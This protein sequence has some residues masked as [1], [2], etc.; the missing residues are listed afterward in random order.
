PSNR[1]PTIRTRTSG[2]PLASSSSDS[3]HLDAVTFAEMVVGPE[4]EL[5]AVIRPFQEGTCRLKGSVAFVPLAEI[6]VRVRCPLAEM[7]AAPKGER[8]AGK[9]P[10][11]PRGIPRER[12]GH[13]SLSPPSGSSAAPSPA[14]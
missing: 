6:V 13:L 11:A 14:P 7:L 2:K 4:H 3:R 12:G 10:P 5:G 1:A 8:G 9:P